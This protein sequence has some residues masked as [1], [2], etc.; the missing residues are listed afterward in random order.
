MERLPS[1]VVVPLGLI[2][3]WYQQLK[4]FTTE[5]AFQ[6]IVYSMD[7]FDA[8]SFF[9]PGGIWDKHSKGKNAHRTI[10]LVSVSVC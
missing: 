5:G 10:I 6:V 2:P 4:H 1:V 9:E 7:Q 3:Q 8:V